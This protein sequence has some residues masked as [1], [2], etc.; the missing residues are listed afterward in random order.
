MSL[1]QVTSLLV[2]SQPGSRKAAYVKTIPIFDSEGQF[3]NEAAKTP[4]SNCVM[5]SSKLQNAGIHMTHIEQSVKELLQIGNH[6]PLIPKS[7]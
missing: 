2:K 7:S 6:E 5:D 1:I 3:L 4:R